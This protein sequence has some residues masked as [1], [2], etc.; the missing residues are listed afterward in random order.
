VGLELDGSRHGSFVYDRVCGPKI[1]ADLTSCIVVGYD[2]PGPCP[3]ARR[4]AEFTL[5][6]GM[7]DFTRFRLVDL[8]KPHYLSEPHDFGTFRVKDHAS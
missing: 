4:E 8:L 1:D 7:S 3:A 5:N 2:P 6:P